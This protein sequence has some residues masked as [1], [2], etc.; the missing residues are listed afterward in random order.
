MGILNWKIVVIGALG[1]LAIFLFWSGK[2]EIPNDPVRISRQEILSG[3]TFSV[4]AIKSGLAT[5]TAGEIFSAAKLAYDLSRITAGKDLVFEYDSKSDNLKKMTYD[6]NNQEQLIVSRVAT[7]TG[8]VWVAEKIEIQYDTEVVSAK[9]VIEES[10]YKT[11]TSDGLDQRVALALAEMFAWQIDFAGEIQKGDSF[12]VIY[13]KKY[14]NGE[15]DHPGNILAAEFVNAG[16]KYQGFYFDGNET[17]DGYYDE[18]GD[19]LQR[20]FLKAPLQFKYISSGFTLKRVHPING[21]YSPHRAIDYAAPSGTPV[22]AVGDGTIIQ[23]GWNSEFGGQY[24]ISVKIRHNSTYTTV[25]GHLSGVAKGI[26]AG[27]KVRQGQV[28]AYVGSTGMSTGPHLHYEM[29][30]FGSFINPANEIFPAVKPVSGPDMSTFDIA[31]SEYQNKLNS[32]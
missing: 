14:R 9:G 4:M 22:V 26:R 10:L 3:S 23:A 20:V 30:K 6:I 12:K 19:S 5:S 31:K 7:G 18:K 29:Y 1:I 15:Y 24:G 28:I 21:G 8:E 25:Y 27:T 32:I 13:E 16:Q 17:A 2:V 11:A